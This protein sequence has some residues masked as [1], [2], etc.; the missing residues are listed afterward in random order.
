MHNTEPRHRFRRAL[1]GR[2]R[3]PGVGLVVLLLTAVLI[4]G[5]GVSG[6]IGKQLDGTVGDI[7]FDQEER[8]T[9]V[10]NAEEDL[11][12]D[13]EGNPLSVVVRIY[14]LDSLTAFNAAS[15]DE[16]W[17]SSDDALGD[18]LLSERE[19][20]VLPGEVAL[21]S[22]A[23]AQRAAYVAVVAFFRQMP[24]QR[25]RLVFDAA[26]MRKDGI[27]TSPDGVVLSLADSH[28]QPVGEDSAELIAV[29]NA[30]GRFS[31]P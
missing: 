29:A 21:D 6:R 2:K 19:V 28:I 10:L 1:S 11:N 17:H 26:A 30:M 18:S 8:V 13:T 4:S 5:C 12:P 16:L 3:H 24:D 25:W 23:M 15:A 14:Q 31:A 9:V 7:L 27:L 22:A 20:V